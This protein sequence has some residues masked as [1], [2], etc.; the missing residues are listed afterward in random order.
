MRP[1]DCGRDGLP[2]LRLTLGESLTSVVST[3]ACRDGGAG[4]DCSLCGSLKE[5][6]SLTLVGVLGMLLVFLNLSAPD[7]TLSVLELSLP[8]S[9]PFFDNSPDLNFRSP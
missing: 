8:V 3:I 2:L 9:N 7:L 6:V 1:G 5:E 4:L